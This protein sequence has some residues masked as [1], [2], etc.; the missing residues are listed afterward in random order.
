MIAAMSCPRKMLL[1]RTLD[2]EE[3]DQNDDDHG[4]QDNVTML[5]VHCTLDIGDIDQGDDDHGCYGH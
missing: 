2:I 3:I 1:R 5:I 4:G